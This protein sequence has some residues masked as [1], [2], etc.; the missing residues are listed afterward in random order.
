ML[1]VGL[2]SGGQIQRLAQQN[3]AS[4]AIMSNAVWVPCL[5][6]G[7]LPGVVYCL[8]LMKKNG[9]GEKLIQSARW[10]Y[11]VMATLMG[12]LWFGSVVAYSLATVKLGELGPVIGW[13]LFMSCV[14][15]VSMF[16]GV[17]TGSGRTQA[18]GRSL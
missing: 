16:T 11:W 17:I 5:W 1:N 3:G 2:A 4:Q 13:P 18:R 12:R 10:Y 7:F 6:A 15:I 9:T 8:Y 14:V